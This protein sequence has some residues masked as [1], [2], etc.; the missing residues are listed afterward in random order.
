L[1]QMFIILGGGPGDYSVYKR[2]ALVNS[3][4]RRCTNCLTVEK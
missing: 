1:A 3:M 4:L 2:Y